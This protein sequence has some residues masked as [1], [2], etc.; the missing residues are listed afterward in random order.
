MSRTLLQLL[1]TAVL[2]TAAMTVHSCVQGPIYE[3][4]YSVAGITAPTQVRIGLSPF[5][6]V[7]SAR[8]TIDS[9][10][11]ATS[12]DGGRFLFDGTKLVNEEIA[13][14]PEG[15][16]IGRANR[17]YEKSV[18]IT[19]YLGGSILVGDRRFRGSLVIHASEMK[20]SLVNEV[21]MEEYLAGVIAKEMSLSESPD[22]LKAQIVAA[23]SYAL[24]EVRSRPILRP[25]AIFD[26]Y[27]D[28]RSQV[29]G[30]ICGD[31]ALATRL[32]RETRGEIVAFNNNVL[33]TYYSSTCG[34]HTE[35]AAEI[36]DPGTRDIVPL[37][38]RP[39]GKCSGSKYFAWEAVL[40]KRELIEKLF[41]DRKDIKDISSI[42]VT[43]T[44]KGGHALKIAIGLPGAK[45]IEVDANEGFRHKIN[46]NAAGAN[47]VLRSTLF[48]VVPSG[49]SYRF[50]GK[51]FGHAVGMCQTGAYQL[52]REGV[53][54]D[55]I[56]LYYYPG[57]SV[58][59]LY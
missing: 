51:G 59:K 8:I 47:K 57:A 22:A 24:H 41:P 25:T 37:S 13:P 16:T 6:S 56:L 32:V 48:T 17:I 34:G 31:N 9:S 14:F 50:A 19:P 36:L 3:D 53:P 20:I 23:R 54:Y 18:R 30:G 43:K 12:P 45:E 29:Y 4:I 27:D 26:L 10:F 15:I 58:I 46:R 35:P 39:C 38:G 1:T 42:R 2:I 7:P 5:L 21:D 55:Y 33:K 40:T 44:A 52:A 11:R 49:S 28:Q